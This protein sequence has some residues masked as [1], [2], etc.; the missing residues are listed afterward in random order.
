MSLPIAVLV[1]GSGSNLQSIIDRIND[2]VLDAEIKLVVSNKAGAYGIERAKKNGIPYKV[3]RHTDFTSREAFDQAMVSAITDAGVGAGPGGEGIVVMA[4]FMRI[5]TPVF[6]GAFENRVINIHPALLPS[7]TGA[8]GQSD[9]AEYGVK[10]SGCT[11]HF[12]DEQMDHG[13]V[14]IQAAVPCQ[15]GEDGNTLGPR[16]LK[17]EHRVFP[18]AIQWISENR[19]V[20]KD[21]HVELKVSGKPCAGQPKADIEPMTYALVWP[22][23]E[24]GF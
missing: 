3:L 6:L 13:P 17:L 9:A 10:I 22:P 4:G 16:I 24:E 21:R 18:Q 2:G 8:H 23:L 20:I 11:V 12:V 14:I 1:S 5:V 15:A 19:L 7:F